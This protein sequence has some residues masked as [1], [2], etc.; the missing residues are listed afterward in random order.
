[1]HESGPRVSRNRNRRL[2][3]APADT[4]DFLADSGCADAE[5]LLLLLLLLP[6]F[7]AVVHAAP[8]TC[9]LGVGRFHFGRRRMWLRV[10]PG[11]VKPIE[12]AIAELNRLPQGSVSER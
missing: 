11:R 12:T 10:D 3:V 2:Q 4:A 9:R 5:L 8:A 1:M 6:A 7:I